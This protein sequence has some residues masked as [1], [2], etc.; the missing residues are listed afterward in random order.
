MSWSLVLT[1]FPI[2]FCFSEKVNK[3][4]WISESEE[5]V[6]APLVVKNINVD[7]SRLST[8]VLNIYSQICTQFQGCADFSGEF[9]GL[10]ALC[11]SS[12]TWQKVT[13]AHLTCDLE[14][15]S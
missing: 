15:D 2:L 13:T 12:H 7:V 9:N 10:H 5:L 3:H 6:N 1:K 8:Q 4:P 11:Y 14:A